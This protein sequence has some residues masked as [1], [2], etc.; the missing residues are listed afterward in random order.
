MGLDE[1][2]V[3]VTSSNK[4]PPMSKKRLAWTIVTMTMT[5]LIYAS[6]HMTRKIPSVVTTVIHPVAGDGSSVYGIPVADGNNGT[7]N[8]TGWSPFNQDVDPIYINQ[9]SV[10]L[11][12][13]NSSVEGVNG[14][15]FALDDVAFSTYT[16]KNS[17]R[18]VAYCTNPTTLLKTCGYN[19]SVFGV[20]NTWVVSAQRTDA[21]SSA[22]VLYAANTSS[23]VPNAVGAWKICAPA[24]E[25]DAAPIIA[26]NGV[27]T[28]KELWGDMITLYLAF[29]AAGLFFA[30]H[31]GDRMNLKLF[32][33]L[34]MLGSASTVALIGLGYYFNITSSYY[35]WIIFGVQ[36]LFQA[37][38]WPAVVALTG[39]W[40]GK[41][42]RGLAMGIWNAHTSVGN[43]LGDYIGL[44]GL[45]VAMPGFSCDNNWPMAFILAGVA[46][47]GVN[48]ICLFVLK[49]H[50]SKVGLEELD[51]E[52]EVEQKELTGSVDEQLVEIDSK[53]KQRPT[54]IRA[55]CTP[56]LVEFA[57]CLF[58][59]KLVAYTFIYWGP[60]Y[61]AH[62]GL[63]AVA[64]AK[65]A[66][67]FDYGGIIGG[68]GA[69]FLA[70]R[71]KSQA[72]VAFGCLVCGIA[73]LF[74]FQKYTANISDDQLTEYKLLMMMVGAFI[75][76]PYALI[77]TAVSADL[78]TTTK[79]DDNLL[80]T[81]T[82]I[83]DGTG[84]IGAAIQGA[85][86]GYV[87]TKYDWSVVFILLMI[88]MAV[89]ALMLLRLVVRDTRLLCCKSHKQLDGE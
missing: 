39:P 51:A 78:G 42:K 86:I 88:F 20:F 58:F 4:K 9:A 82:G 40:L 85:L 33:S 1:P 55:L 62:S 11:V 12:V 44:A 52:E 47:T 81:V 5:F 22:N 77:T 60:N 27:T 57:V 87:S 50:P 35:Y 75:N 6:F 59:C 26:A 49:S 76:A 84:S 15:Y 34:G 36:G 32:V 69:G 25:T 37:T 65:Y 31:I 72:W 23:P 10:G 74:V 2:L 30:G 63:S 70:D 67:F 66:A 19:A 18:V 83:I 45:Q 8:N 28:G 13:S 3:E 48:L 79:G 71:V 14:T 38:G 73:A 61:V 7:C 16:Q 43:I 54:F 17:S 89:S 53:A 68:I 64:A 56:G 21:C 46:M 80:A 41:G 29:Y 24:G